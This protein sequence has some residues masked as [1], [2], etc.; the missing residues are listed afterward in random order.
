M[1]R[2]RLSFPPL[3]FIGFSLFIVLFLCSMSLFMPMAEDLFLT[4]GQ[5]QITPRIPMSAWI[6]MLMQNGHLLP[7]GVVKIVDLWG[8]DYFHLSGFW[9]VGFVLAFGFCTYEYVRY[10]K[11]PTFLTPF[12]ILLIGL[13]GFW[14]ELILP[15]QNYIH[16]GFGLLGSAMTL[17]S[18][19][20][21]KRHFFLS[22]AMASLWISVVFLS[23][24]PLA[25]IP[26]FAVSLALISPIFL[27][28]YPKN[29]PSFQEIMPLIFGFFV[30]ELLLLIIHFFL[31]QSPY[32]LDLSWIS[33]QEN[34]LHY[35]MHI[36][37]LFFPF[38]HFHYDFIFPIHERLLYGVALLSIGCMLLK[39]SDTSL[40]FYG[41]LG[42]ILGLSLSLGPPYPMLPSLDG[43]IS[44]RN[45]AGIPFFHGG[46]LLIATLATINFLAQYFPRWPHNTLFFGFTF[47]TI[48][49][50][51]GNQ[52]SILYERVRQY[53]QDEAMAAHLISDLRKEGLLY[54]EAPIAIVSHPNS[55][56]QLNRIFSNDFPSSA[57]R[58]QGS[59][60]TALLSRSSG[61]ALK[62]IPYETLRSS[63]QNLW[64]KT[65]TSEE[66][67]NRLCGQT[68]YPWRIK[69][70]NT[71]TIVC[72]AGKN[73]E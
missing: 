70:T 42:L 41:V 26:L 13:H 43:V 54:Q 64:R 57:L 50:S 49:F 71:F 15:L 22:C 38:S 60:G 56:P 55:I 33:F 2:G 40:R 44:P 45:L 73:I 23:Y 58:T 63:T 39:V 17:L 8:Y 66:F 25:V 6:A 69:K 47:I 14:G 72:V 20:R 35:I 1:I 24:P 7:A 32:S 31:P 29:P 16:Y 48:A 27:D 52:L 21:F 59:A 3:I 10:I 62:T 46:L 18:V 36:P 37:G 19:R 4:Y 61:I 51:F 65:E 28:Y 68:P 9:L 11:L 30:G 67:Y 34:I 5:G 53:T 12:L